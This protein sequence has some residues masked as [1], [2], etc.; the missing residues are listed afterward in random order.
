LSVGSIAQA[1]QD[2][3]SAR[4]WPEPV[5]KSD[6]R[7]ALEAMETR[8]HEIVKAN[9][10]RIKERQ[11]YRADRDLLHMCLYG[12]DPVLGYG[13]RS[14]AMT[15][16]TAGDPLAVNVVKAV[17]STLVSRVVKMKP[18]SNW[19]TSGGDFYLQQQAKQL[20]KYTD[21]LFYQNKVYKLNRIVVRDS[22]IFGTGAVSGYDWYGR[23][24]VERAFTPEMLVDDGEAKYGDPPT[25]Y[26]PMTMDKGVVAEIYPAFADKIRAAKPATDDDWQTYDTTKDQ[27]EV[28]RAWHRK[29]G[30]NADDGRRIVC[31]ENCTLE[32]D[33]YK[34]EGFGGSHAFL[35]YEEPVLGWYGTGLAR[36]LTGK[37]LEINKLLTE[38]QQS[39]HMGSNFRVL[40]ERGSKILKTHFNNE[41]GGVL[42]YTGTAP[43]FAVAQT[44]HPEKFQH[45][46]WL[47]QESFQ[48]AGI[49]QLTAAGQKDPTLKSGKAQQVALDVEDSRYVDFIQ[50]YEEFCMEEADLLFNIAKELKRPVVMYLGK[51]TYE[52]IDIADI[53]LTKESF[54]LQKFPTSALSTSP[55][56]RMEQVQD[57][58]NAGWI[59]PA[60][61]K[62]M[63]DFPDLETSQE[64]D[65]APYDIVMESLDLMLEEGE[66]HA[67]IPQ[68]DLKLALGL[69]VNYYLRARVK[70]KD[71][72][73]P[74]NLGLIL[75]FMSEVS[76]MLNPPAPPPQPGAAAPQLPPPGPGGPPPGMPPMPGGEMPQ[77]GPPPGAP[78]Q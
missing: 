3:R 8:P 17:I 24:K 56:R 20:D 55:D 54:V 35:R 73:D 13:V 26:H 18:K 43:T 53:D 27:V 15:D 62:R 1:E 70:F 30:P 22:L 45:L 37:Q 32:Y 66:Y 48:E 67:P 72:V 52:E 69:S 42:E 36:L 38:I 5:P 9:L 33:D 49:N 16:P 65:S 57:L 64:L 7:E 50:S 14:Y 60:D 28:Y 11:S 47:I 6:S 71:S 23:P 39:F 34:H 21:G 74:K 46:I 63:L 25:L 2:G 44:V 40:V 61:A 31:L 29:S 68:M 75:Q 58:A 10:K 12:S 19:V 41:I 51:N 59:T 4:W 78:I 76:A 77:M